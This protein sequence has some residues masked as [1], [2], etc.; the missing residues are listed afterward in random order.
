MKTLL[1][2]INKMQL[3]EK[4]FYFT[5]SIVIFFFLI[6]LLIDIIK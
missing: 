3:E 6:K 1:N 2:Y 5:G 4:L